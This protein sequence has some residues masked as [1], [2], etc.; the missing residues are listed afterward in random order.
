MKIKIEVLCDDANEAADVANALASLRRLPVIKPEDN[1]E[2]GTD[3]NP[4]LAD[5]FKDIQPVSRAVQL[6]PPHAAALANVGFGGP[7]PAGATP[8]PVVAAP[9]VPPAPSTAVAAPAP[10]APA[11]PAPTS[12]ANVPAPPAPAAPPAPPAAAPSVPAAPTNPVG[13]D[14]A[15][16]P[17]DARIHGSTKTQNKD[18]TWRAKR[19]VLPALVVSVEAELRHLMGLNASAAPLPPAPPAPPAPPPPAPTTAAAPG[20]SPSDAPMS[21]GAFME[22]L[23]PHMMTNP[24]KLTTDQMAVALGK[25]GLTGLGQLAITPNL[26]PAVMAELEPLLA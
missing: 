7:L 12:T 3:L 11:A 21:F 16:L 8:I 4:S 6:R 25:F 10:T 9:L 26:L 24:P 22:R 5:L 14:K 1:P 2:A 18:G 17:W 20:A 19:D 13:V 15:G 23:T